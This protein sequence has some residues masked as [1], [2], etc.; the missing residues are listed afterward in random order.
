MILIDIDDF[1]YVLRELFLRFRIF[2]FPYDHSL[3]S[4]PSR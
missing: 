4:W 3:G 2:L 1:Y